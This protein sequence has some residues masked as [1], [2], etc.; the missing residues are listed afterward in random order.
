MFL[1]LHGCTPGCRPGSCVSVSL[2]T[3]KWQTGHQ[4][5]RRP[6]AVMGAGTAPA[7]M[8][9]ADIHPLSSCDTALHQILPH[10]VATCCPLVCNKRVRRTTAPRNTTARA[11]TAMPAHLLWQRRYWRRM[12]CQARCCELSK[13]ENLPQQSRCAQ[14][15][16]CTCASRAVS[17]GAETGR[18][19]DQAP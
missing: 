15:A 4:T 9:K 6:A 7:S 10:A 2:A 18:D 8:W 17:P 16:R 19:R 14:I 3:P 13:F 5:G 11:F 12:S 1:E